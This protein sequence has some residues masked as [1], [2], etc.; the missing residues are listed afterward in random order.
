[1]QIILSTGE[2]IAQKV[3]Y[4]DFDY[5]LLFE[6]GVNIH[7]GCWYLNYLQEKFNKRDYL[8]ISGYNAGPGITD[9]WIESID[10]ND[11][12]SFVEN[13][14]YQE[15]TEHIKKVMRTYIIYQ[16]IYQNKKIEPQ[17]SSLTN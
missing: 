10:M 5:D 17:T 7:F 13:I 15:T 9:Q 1:M 6:P 11:I 16:I 4:Q 3:N 14:P 12:D 2:W 8:M